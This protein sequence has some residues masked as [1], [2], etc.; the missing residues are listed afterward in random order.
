M[1]AP[2]YQAIVTKFIG[3]SNVKGSRVK[4]KAAAGSLTLHWDHS[5]N[6]DDNHT[7]A[8]KALAEKLAWGG[9]WFGGGMPDGSG[10]VFV[11]VLG[12]EARMAA[13]AGHAAFTVEVP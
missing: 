7:K 3:P 10:N 2:I 11:T 6:G 12:C 1:N 4:A 5:L 8:A 9:V 13:K